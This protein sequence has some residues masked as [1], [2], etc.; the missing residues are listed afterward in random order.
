[1]E[2][3]AKLVVEMKL[4]HNNEELHAVKCEQLQQG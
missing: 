2:K 1:M 4:P 3:E